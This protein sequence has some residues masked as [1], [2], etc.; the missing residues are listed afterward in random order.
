VKYAFEMGSGA[1]ISKPNFIK[2][3]SV[4]QKLTWGDTQTD[5]PE[6]GDLVSLLY[7]FKIREVGKKHK[8]YKRNSIIMA[9]C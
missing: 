2:I 3:V 9:V 4:I 6:H 8:H 7:V 1:L 5:T